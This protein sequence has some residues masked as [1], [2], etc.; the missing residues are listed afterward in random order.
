MPKADE[1]GSFRCRKSSASVV[2][3]DGSIIQPEGAVGRL[4]NTVML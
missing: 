2:S 1:P 3:H 4:N